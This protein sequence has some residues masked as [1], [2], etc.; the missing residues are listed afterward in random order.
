MY[1]FTT[2]TDVP[3]VDFDQPENYTEL[4]YW[5]KHP[6]LHGWMEAL[7]RRKGG[8]DESFNVVPVRLEREDIDALEAAIAD[9]ALPQTSG[10]FFGESEGSER[11]DDAAFIRKARDALGNG[12]A[13][14]YWSWW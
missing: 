11:E 4:H 1:A 12:R 9:G 14:F 8:K 10:F 2:N 13:V 3:A 6:N 7:Y 5:R